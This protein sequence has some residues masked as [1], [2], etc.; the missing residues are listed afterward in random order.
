MCLCD[1]LPLAIN[2][3]AIHQKFKKKFNAETITYKV[4]TASF[5]VDLPFA[6]GMPQITFSSNFT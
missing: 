6:S 4:E 3:E 1:L 5:E 2:T